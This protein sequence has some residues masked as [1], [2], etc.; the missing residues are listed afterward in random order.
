MSVGETTGAQHIKSTTTQNVVNEMEL[1]TYSEIVSQVTA[2][3]VHL[4]EASKARPV[5]GLGTFERK[6][7]EVNHCS[8]ISSSSV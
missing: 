3:L 7:Q 2:T 4:R 6:L 8:G 5:E 1:E